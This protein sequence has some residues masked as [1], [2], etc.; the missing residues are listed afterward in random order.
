LDDLQV[1]LHVLFGG[2]QNFLVHGASEEELVELLNSLFIDFG[3]SRFDYFYEFIL[4]S[5]LS[6]YLGKLRNY[7]RHL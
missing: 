5:A 6:I 7:L 1:V 2:E 4:L 3:P